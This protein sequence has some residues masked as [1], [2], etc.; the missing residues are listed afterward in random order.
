MTVLRPARRRRGLRVVISG[1]DLPTVS[2]VPGV[3]FVA[4]EAKRLPNT[5]NVFISG[6][7]AQTVLMNLDMQGVCVS[8]GSACSAG[9]TEPS[10]VLLAMGMSEEKA[11]QCLRVSLGWSTTPQE[12]SEFV[13][14]LSA[15]VERLRNI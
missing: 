3:E 13:N 2:K 11:K 15:V 10:P 4:R 12:L 6:V 8:T 7:A 9:S 14:K 1:S 5:S